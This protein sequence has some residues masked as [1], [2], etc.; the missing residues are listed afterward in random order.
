MKEI[1]LW[2][3]LRLAFGPILGGI[4]IDFTDLATFG[5]FGIYAG[6]IIGGGVGYWVASLYRLSKNQRIMIA[7]LS[8]VYCAMPGTEFI[9]VATIIGAGIRFLSPSFGRTGRE[10]K[11]VVDVEGKPRG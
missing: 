6:M 4:I 1:G 9:P 7:L 11:D 8:G 2:E 10:R 3:R 5:P